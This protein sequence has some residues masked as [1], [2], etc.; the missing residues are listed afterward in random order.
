MSEVLG[1]SQGRLVDDD[2][3]LVSFVSEFR[4]GILN[5]RPS[6]GYCAM[7]VWPLETLLNMLGVKCRAV[8]SD[9]GDFNHFWLLLDDGRA[10]DPTA[11]QFWV[12]WRIQPKLPPVYLGARTIAHPLPD[13]AQGPRQAPSTPS[14]EGE[15]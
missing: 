13:A 15:R 6:A 1:A 4:E 10:L 7:V 14:T 2:E 5:G 11:D 9:L 3:A 8:E 12:R